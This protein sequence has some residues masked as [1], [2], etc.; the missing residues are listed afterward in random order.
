MR[1]MKSKKVEPEKVEVEITISDEDLLKLAKYAQQEDITINEAANRL[2]W[3]YIHGKVKK[4][5]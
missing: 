5:R 3:E 2:L 4:A 1:K